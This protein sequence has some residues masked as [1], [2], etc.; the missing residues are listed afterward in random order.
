MTSTKQVM[1]NRRNAEKSTGPKST[2]GKAL[3][4]Y[5]ALKHG[6]TAR[7]AVLPDEDV[8]TFTALCDALCAELEPAGALQWC[9]FDV[10]LAKL[11]RLRRAVRIE[12]EILQRDRDVLSAVGDNQYSLGLTFIR[13]CNQAESLLKLTRY[14]VTLENSFKKTLDHLRE[15]QTNEKE[16]A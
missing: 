3:V 8:E 6:L 10:M 1:A 14:E 16:L 5:N 15:L 11:W 4:R 9:L 7:H 2:D 12:G 13:D